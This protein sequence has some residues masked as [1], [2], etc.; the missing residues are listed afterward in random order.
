MKKEDA[1]KFLPLVQAFADGKT[2][3]FYNEC[4]IWVDRVDLGFVYEIKR[5]RVKPEP[6]TFEAFLTPDGTIWPL[7]VTP[8]VN[9]ER[10]TVQEVLK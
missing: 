2:I 9:W 7:H 4:G 10:I 3:Q 8:L 5:Y 6:R 1:H